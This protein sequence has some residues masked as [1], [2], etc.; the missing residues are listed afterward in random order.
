MTSTHIYH[1]AFPLYMEYD[2]IG[3]EPPAGYRSWMA[4]RETMRPH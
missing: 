3:K 4:Y 2:R 1:Y